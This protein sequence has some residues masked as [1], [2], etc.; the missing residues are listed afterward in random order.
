MTR[1]KRQEITW[2][3]LNG[4]GVHLVSKPP[5]PMAANAKKF[6]LP[7]QMRKPAQG[8]PPFHYEVPEGWEKG[9]LTGRFMVE[10][11]RGRQGGVSR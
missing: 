6:Q 2:I 7:A 8:K 4:L 1:D 10:R 5:E 11:L 3:D 9:P